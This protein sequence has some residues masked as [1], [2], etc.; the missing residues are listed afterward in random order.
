[1]NSFPGTP[2]A[3][4][5]TQHEDIADESEVGMKEIFKQIAFTL[6]DSAPTRGEQEYVAEQLTAAPGQP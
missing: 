1:M 3:E 4:L 5:G 6:E 2:I